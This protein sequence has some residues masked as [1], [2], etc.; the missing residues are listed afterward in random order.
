[1]FTSICFIGMDIVSR[2]ETGVISS[3]HWGKVSSSFIIGNGA[4]S[5]EIVEA[6]F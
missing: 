3:V 1:M 6:S 2:G 5:S 4:A